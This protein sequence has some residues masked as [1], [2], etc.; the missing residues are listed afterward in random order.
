[1]AKRRVKGIP[2][3][4]DQ[5]LAEDRDILRLEARMKGAKLV[6]YFGNGDNVEVID[7]TERL[8][9]FFPQDLVRG[10][11]TCFS[12]LHGVFL[13][14]EQPKNEH[15]RLSA[16][17]RMIADVAITS[18]A[19]V[20]RIGALHLQSVSSARIFSVASRPYRSLSK[21]V[22]A[23]WKLDAT[24]AALSMLSDLPMTQI[25]PGPTRAQSS[26][27]SVRMHQRMGSSSSLARLRAASQPMS[28]RPECLA[29]LYLAG[30]T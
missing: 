7:G 18:G 24:L 1:M 28:S 29:V 13:P 25:P 14:A 27:P 23:S 5:K 9:W 11:R 6:H 3:L 22:I 30:R 26:G 8:V 10:H 17:G 19:T 20:V 16:L 4:S 12:E 21:A 15:P 2:L